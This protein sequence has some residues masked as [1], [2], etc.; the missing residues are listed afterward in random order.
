MPQEI[1]DANDLPGTDQDVIDMIV[2]GV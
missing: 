1:E 2:G